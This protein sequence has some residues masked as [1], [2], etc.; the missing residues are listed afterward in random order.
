MLGLDPTLWRAQIGGWI[1]RII[2]IE[3]L[4]P[5]EAARWRPLVL[6]AIQFVFSHLSDDRLAAK[7]AGQSELPADTPPEQRLIRLISRMPALQKIGQVLARNR[8]LSPALRSALIELENG[9]SDVTIGEIRALIVEQLGPR[10]EEYEVKMDSSILSEASVAA[11][12]RFTSRHGERERE[13]GVFKVLKP[14]VLDCLG[15][16]MD[17]LRRLGRHLA[18]PERGYGF[19]VH[20]VQEMLE[21]VRL[22]LEHEL[23]FTREQATLATAARMYR[24]SIGIRVPRLFEGL[25]TPRITAMT[26]EKA[27]KVTSACRRSPI[28]RE[29]IA[30]QLI[31][32]LIA[33]P[34]FTRETQAVFH[35]DPHAG[36]L[37]YDEPNREL[38]VLDWALAEHLDRESRRR[39]ILL[40]LMTIFRNP[41]GVIDAVAGLGRGSS[42]LIR[43]GV[44]RFFAAM[45]DSYSPGTLDA[46]RLLDDLA[47]DGVRFPTALFLFRKMLFTLDGVLHDVAA[48]EVRMDS[49]I[50]RDFL[51]RWAASF[52]LFH[53][54]LHLKD[55]AT[56]PWKA[57]AHQARQWMK[58]LRPAPTRKRKSPRRARSPQPA[59]PPA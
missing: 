1:S 43:R 8:R 23:D 45:P 14:Y 18:S 28:R 13:R 21:E 49:V 24:A 39:L 17:L 10:L 2:P 33:V 22:L 41:D 52:G 51:T 48:A 58:K 42:R 34:L 16:D 47:L 4:V 53:A 44:S 32:A 30:E 54:P 27:V 40:V 15:E 31:E 19:A 29:R 59:L 35:G 5:D 46:M 56:V 20:D 57:V 3:T 36:N 25:C 7:I 12:V 38:V 55:V 6:D 11:V 50:T 9:M 26:E 37:L